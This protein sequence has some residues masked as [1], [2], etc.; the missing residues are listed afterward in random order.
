MQMSQLNERTLN[1]LIK[2][3]YQQLN[4]ADSVD[5]LLSER[6]LA[7][8][9]TEEIGSDDL[10]SLESLA[11]DAKDS[12]QKLKSDITDL[13]LANST[14][15]IDKLLEEIPD[16]PDLVSV[17]IEGDSK[18]AA[19][20]IGKIAS[21]TKKANAFRDSYVKAISL[22]G[23][24][25]SKLDVPNDADRAKTLKD[26]A[27]SGVGGFPDL[28]K[29]KVG[30]KAAYEPPPEET[31]IFKKISSFFGFGVNFSK[32]QFSED[33]LG[34]SLNDII[35][36]S[37]ELKGDQ[38]EAGSDEAA[39]DDAAEGLEDDLAGLAGGDSSSL[40]KDSG[41]PASEGEASEEEI[42]AAADEVAAAVGSSISKTE[43][44]ALLKKYPEI[45]GKGP[46]A[47]RQR[48]IF[49]KAINKVA[50]KEV[51]EE[52]K[53]YNTQTYNEEEM[54]AYRLSKLAGLE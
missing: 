39:S 32:E 44:T 9:L 46:S 31:G 36:K 13:G 52:S 49:R 48:R 43:L 19:K 33:I 22:F 5:T 28:D 45:S 30:S 11:K 8:L 51:F 37:Q 53:N 27:D 17:A 26:L 12:L 47:T 10:A 16:T 15:Y 38:E 34:T 3:S 41:E 54:I 2:K 35:K 21:A 14:A 4:Y 24:N 7:F 18:K 29:L 42:E 6:R 50:G 20:K 25:L 1:K 40:P 23:D